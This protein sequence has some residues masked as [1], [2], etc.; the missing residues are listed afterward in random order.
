[1]ELP[2]EEIQTEVM[3][4]KCFLGNLLEGEH[5]VRDVSS[6]VSVCYLGLNKSSLQADASCEV[7]KAPRCSISY[8]AAT[9]D[10]LERGCAR[11][12]YSSLARKGLSLQIISRSINKIVLPYKG[13]TLMQQDSYRGRQD[14]GDAFLPYSRCWSTWIEYGVCDLSI[15][16][17]ISERAP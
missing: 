14:A 16:L 5:V 1:M 6:G 4:Y 10:L 3:I 9:Q 13:L 12:R 15:C 8:Q 7:T 17:L 2:N 11:V